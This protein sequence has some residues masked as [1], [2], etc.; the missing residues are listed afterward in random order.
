MVPQQCKVLW[1]LYFLKYPNLSVCLII[2][3]SV[4]PLLSQVA[5]RLFITNWLLPVIDNDMISDQFAFFHIN[6]TT[7]P[8]TFLIH[9]VVTTLENCD[10]AR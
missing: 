9:H 5:E 2:G 1:L 10:F 3:L 6:S 8:V 7:C 4:T